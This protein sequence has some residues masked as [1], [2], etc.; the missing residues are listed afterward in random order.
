MKSIFVS[1]A[2][3]NDSVVL[4]SYI[5]GVVWVMARA[6]GDGNRPLKYGTSVATSIICRPSSLS[7][8]LYLKNGTSKVFVMSGI[9]IMI[10]PRN[11]VYRKCSR[12]RHHSHVHDTP[13]HMYNIHGWHDGGPQQHHNGTIS[14]IMIRSAV[15]RLTLKQANHN[16]SY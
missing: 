15:P 2:C 7:C 13:A 9:G 12:V 11:M 1:L 3:D 10:V 6:Q 5:G 16:P 8:P 4:G 14:T